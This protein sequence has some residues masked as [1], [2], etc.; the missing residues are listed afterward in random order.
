MASRHGPARCLRLLAASIATSPCLDSLPFV[1]PWSMLLVS[2][3]RTLPL[4]HASPL[5]A[6]CILKEV[7][8][9]SLAALTFPYLPSAA[10]SLRVTHSSR[11]TQNQRRQPQGFY[12][13]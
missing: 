1:L 13:R 10:S 12:L 5:D 8:L 6:A 7:P 11:S 4:R 9:P 2:V 3:L